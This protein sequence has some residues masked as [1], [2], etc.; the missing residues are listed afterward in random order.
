MTGHYAD[1]LE[2]LARYFERDLKF[3]QEDYPKADPYT[4]DRILRGIG[5]S[6]YTYYCIL[7]KID[8]LC[9][10]TETLHHLKELKEL[11]D[12][13]AEPQKLKELLSK[14]LGEHPEIIGF[15]REKVNENRS[16]SPPQP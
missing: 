9:G 16:S 10:M 14:V 12:K 2:E 6:L 3:L 1:R 7:E 8:E 11:I 13:P 4:A 15:I 5:E